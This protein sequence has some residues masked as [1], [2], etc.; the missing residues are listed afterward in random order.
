MF[1]LSAR[2][3]LGGSAV[4]PWGQ[5]MRGKAISKLH[6]DGLKPA[7][8]EYFS[9]DRDLKGFGVRVQP[10]G[11]KSYVAKYRVG[12]GRKAPTRRV[13]LGAVGKLTPDEAR[14]LAK[15][16]LGSVAHGRDPAADKA[17]DRSAA[18][19]KELA[20][21]FLSEHVDAKRKPTTASHYRDILE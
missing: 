14:K 10:T 2:F 7:A 16:T 18:T 13:T 8:C 11:E 15:L 4:V 6:V 21:V 3:P 20:D 17:A 19:L 1:E 12:S 5:K 9:W